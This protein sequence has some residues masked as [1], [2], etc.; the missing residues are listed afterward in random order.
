MSK[1][2]PFS[3]RRMF[4]MV[5]MLCVAA[6][7]FMV[8]LDVRHDGGVSPGI[9]QV[10]L[11]VGFSAATGTA[12]GCVEGRPRAGAIWGAVIGVGIGIAWVTIAQRGPFE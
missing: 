12:L 11:C 9:F 10:F 5:A 6:R 2:F 1:P 8:F 3:M 4:G 7:L